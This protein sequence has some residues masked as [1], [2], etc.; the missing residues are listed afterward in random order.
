M[1]L[2][3]EKVGLVKKSEKVSEIHSVFITEMVNHICKR[4]KEVS[5]EEDIE[6][7]YEEKEMMIELNYEGTTFMVSN[8]GQI[9]SPDGKEYH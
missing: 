8:K 4:G 2:G 7:N 9:F 3:E 6:T 5:M 1:E